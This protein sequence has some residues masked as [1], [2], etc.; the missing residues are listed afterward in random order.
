[1]SLSKNPSQYDDIRRVLDSARENNGGRFRCT[2]HGKAV[3][4]R[5]RA[6]MFR[7]LLFKL[8]QQHYLN[9]PGMLATTPYDGMKLIV[10]DCDVWIEF[11]EPEGELLSLEGELVMM[12]A[13]DDPLV[14]EAKQ[15]LKSLELEL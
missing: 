15:L 14:E 10:K 7:S 4:W 6:Y 9:I 1:M 13:V 11:V 8:N 12:E 5:A 2:S 3:G